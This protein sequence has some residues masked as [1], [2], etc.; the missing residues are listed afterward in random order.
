MKHLPTALGN[1]ARMGWKME[2]RRKFKYD[3]FAMDLTDFV[4]Q[5]GKRR[6]NGPGGMRWCC[7][8]YRLTYDELLGL[9][10]AELIGPSV[11]GQSVTDI[12]DTEQYN[13]DEYKLRRMFLNKYDDVDQYHDQF[14]RT[15]ELIEYQGAVPEELLDS[16]RA[17]MEEAEGLDP[18]NRLM[19]VANRKIVLE[20]VAL[21]WDHGM[22]SFIEV[23]CI[24][25][26]HDFYGKG[27]IE[28][29]EH[30]IYVGNE[31]RNMRVD[32]VKA[33]I[34]SLIGVDGQRMPT[35]WKRRLVSQPYGV[36]ET[37]G[38]PSEV[39]QRFPLG[40]VTG[41]SYE[42]VS[43]LWA[44][45]QESAAVN[46]TLMGG[47][48]PNRT[49]GEHQLKAETASK[50]L[51][52]ELIGQAQQLL[53][54]PYGLAGFI[55]ALDRQYLPLP[56]YINV[57]DPKTPDDFMEF[58]VD[59]TLFEQED[60]LFTYSPTGA[61]EGINIQAKRADL[62]QMLEALQPFGPLLMQMG[63]NMPEMVRTI[64]KTFGHDPQ[65]F[66]QKV[67]GVAAAGEGMVPGM[68]AQLP[69]AGV[70]G[71]PPPGGVPGG[72]VNPLEQALGGLYG[73]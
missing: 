26:P 43:A 67:E 28:P 21:P 1:V 69:Q 35:G 40:D 39:V 3:A 32:N 30:L 12:Q 58:N 55:I 27:K 5:P 73:G 2:E 50:R 56:T 66:F 62:V 45:A 6:I 48:G 70:P 71:Q 8:T 19:I 63:F 51:Q 22:K 14:E 31:I 17:R 61:V 49:L 16:E 53:G 15:V 57:V 42:E 9:E 41:S 20:D 10:Q 24:P 38:P 46:E 25:D 72:G 65:K 60:E 7:R 18:S 54:F 4:P 36:L 59:H 33:G 13:L 11:G 68:G 37:N 64:M 23:D 29:N 44:D 52:F 47:P 34:N